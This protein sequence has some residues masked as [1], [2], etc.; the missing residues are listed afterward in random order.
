LNR[1]AALCTLRKNLPEA[2]Q[3]RKAEQLI[4]EQTL[5]DVVQAEKKLKASPGEQQQKQQNNSS[6][7]NDKTD[8]EADL[9]STLWITRAKD[10]KQLAELMLSEGK[11]TLARSYAQKA[12][13]CHQQAT[14]AKH[15]EL[16]MAQVAAVGRA[17]YLDTMNSFNQQRQTTDNNEN[18]E[19]NHQ[20][21]QAT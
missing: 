7:S 5:L 8:E 4:Y 18:T 2:L 3:Y 20:E 19:L 11:S 12:L 16:R 13:Y 17:Q 6:S 10:H 21:S 1:L 15:K 14:K 9:G